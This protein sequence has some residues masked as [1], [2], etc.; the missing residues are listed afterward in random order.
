MTKDVTDSLLTVDEEC[1]R[2]YF[3]EGDTPERRKKAL[4][5]PRLRRQYCVY[6]CKVMD[7]SRDKCLIYPECKC[8]N[9]WPQGNKGDNIRDVW[10]RF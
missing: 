3:K 9:G 7:G 2:K 8:I 1:L 6:V 5:T 4:V 10:G